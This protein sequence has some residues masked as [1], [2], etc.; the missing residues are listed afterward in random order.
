MQGQTKSLPLGGT[1]GRT[2]R[3][4]N[5]PLFYAAAFLLGIVRGPPSM[6][7]SHT[8]LWEPHDLPDYM[9]EEAEFLLM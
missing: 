5:W 4:G 7:L 9:E 2:L 6:F 1:T 8:Y 3:L